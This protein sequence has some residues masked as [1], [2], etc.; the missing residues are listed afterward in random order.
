VEECC[1]LY[2]SLYR[3]NGHFDADYGDM[4][5]EDKLD[6]V[7]SFVRVTPMPIRSCDMVFLSNCDDAYR[8]YG[9]EHL[10]VLTMLWNADME[11]LECG[12][13]IS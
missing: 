6:I 9:C 13:G 12:H 2:E 1:S 4:T 11:F 8:N 10:G 3:R 5:V 7:E